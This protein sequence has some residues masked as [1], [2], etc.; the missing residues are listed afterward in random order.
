ME[1]KPHGGPDARRRRPLRGSDFLM[2][3]SQGVWSEH[4]IAEAINATGR[5][6]AIAY[7]PSGVA[8]DQQDLSDEYFDRLA[9]AEALGIKRPDLLVVRWAD[10]PRA[11]ELVNGL[12]GPAALQFRHETELRP[13]LDLAVVG[14][15]CENSLWRAERMPAYGKPLKL[16]RR[17]GRLGQA[18][19][20]VLPT[21]I[22][23]KQD[24]GPLLAWQD[25]SRIAIHIWQ[26]FFDRAWGISLQEACRLIEEG[27][28]EPTE[29]VFHAPAAQPRGR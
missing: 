5:Y 16:Q 6:W 7:G 15:E 28:I 3:W 14:L 9:Q 23:K 13:L 18:K 1:P 22:L 11:E 21:V 25:A 17:T 26:V 24:R 12:G 4:R 19:S 20:A 29:Q 2:R 27:A 10:L 8:P